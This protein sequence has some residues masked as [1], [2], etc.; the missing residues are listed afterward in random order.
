[1]NGRDRF[2][3][4]LR[5]ALRRGAGGWRTGLTALALGAALCLAPPAASPARAGS[6]QAAERQCLAG[7][8]PLIRYSGIET[9]AQYQA[10]MRAQSAHDACQMRCARISTRKVRPSFEPI[11]RDARDYYRRNGW[12]SK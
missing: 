4:R 2:R 12:E 7:C 5:R 8:P 11:S 6:W 3:R 1:M 10:R 9:D